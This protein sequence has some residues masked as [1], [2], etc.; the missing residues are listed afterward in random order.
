MLIVSSACKEEM[1]DHVD[2]II[3][4]AG[5][6]TGTIPYTISEEFNKMILKIVI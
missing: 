2:Q 4:D 6:I 3:N 5:A 1:I